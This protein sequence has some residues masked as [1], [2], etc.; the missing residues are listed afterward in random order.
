MNES[1]FKTGMVQLFNQYFCIHARTKIRKKRDKPS[2][3]E[4]Y[5]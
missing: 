1:D 2:V 4:A 5:P 3:G